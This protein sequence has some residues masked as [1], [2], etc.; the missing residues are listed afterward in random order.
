VQRQTQESSLRH[1][2]QAESSQLIRPNK[3]GLGT[4]GAVTKS[5]LRN[6]DAATK[7]RQFECPYNDVIRILMP[8]QLFTLAEKLWSFLMPVSVES[9][10]VAMAASMWQCQII[11]FAWMSRG[12]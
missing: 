4:L 3:A 2:V 12:V 9:Q 1:S 8:E 11:C 5:S 10:V 6:T 7:K